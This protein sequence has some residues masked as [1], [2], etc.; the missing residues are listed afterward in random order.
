RASR[1]NADNPTMLDETERPVRLIVTDDLQRHRGTVFFRLILAI[2]AWIVLG[3]W[4]IAAFFVA[5]AAWFV[6]LARGRCSAGIHG[7]LFAYL[8]Y[9]V[10]ISAYLPLTAN[11]YPGFAPKADYPVRVEVD[12]PAVQR[13]W[14]VALR[15]FL[16]LPALAIASAVGG[17]AFF[18]LPSGR[19]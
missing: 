4:T 8:R 15:I 17:G 16:L 6:V 10:Q 5:I 9:S 1:P 2:P 11:P 12:P 13:R 7:F 14:T 19:R 3:F 18:S